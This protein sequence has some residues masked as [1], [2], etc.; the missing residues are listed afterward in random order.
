MAAW[1]FADPS[2]SPGEAVETKVTLDADKH[3]HLNPLD[4]AA[5]ASRAWQKSQSGKHGRS[6]A[7]PYPQ[8]LQ[9]LSATADPRS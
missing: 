2:H 9:R 1:K 6:W 7:E 8:L 4:G 5:S 3:S